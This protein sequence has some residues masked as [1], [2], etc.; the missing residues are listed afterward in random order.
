MPVPFK[1]IKQESES[2]YDRK[3][4]LEMSEADYLAL[5]Y[6]ATYYGA[7]VATAAPAARSAAHRFSEG[8]VTEYWDLDR[9]RLFSA[10]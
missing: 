4:I 2:I 8:T 10:E 7:V 3:V 6:Y 1:V 9:S 5:R